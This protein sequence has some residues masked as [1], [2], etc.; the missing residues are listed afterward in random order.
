MRTKK[1][2]RKRSGSA[3]GFTLIE[4][5]IVVAIIG[6]LAAIAI[7][8][9]LQAQQ[10]ARY[11]Q[12]VEALKGIQTAMEMYISDHGSYDLQIVAPGV[13]P[14][15]LAMYMIPGCTLQD[16]SGAWAGEVDMR[17]GRNCDNFSIN[18]IGNDYDYEIWGD[19]KE[20]YSCPIC[21]TPAGFAPENYAMCPPPYVR[22]CP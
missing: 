1:L 19:A 17:I 20:R 7:P 22:T 14:D 8:N 15:A 9:F 2:M 18:V 10:K 13:D 3:A 6:I 12:C 16:G 4:L 5:M 21:V 11:T